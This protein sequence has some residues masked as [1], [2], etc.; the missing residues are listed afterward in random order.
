MMCS[1][2]DDQKQ[3]QVFVV[4]HRRGTAV[5]QLVAQKCVPLLSCEC[6]CTQV[7]T[8]IS[9][10]GTTLRGKDQRHA[11]ETT[12]DRSLP[13]PRKCPKI[14]NDYT[15]AQPHIDKNNRFRQFELAIEERFRTRSFPYRLFTTVIAG[16]SIANAF[17]AYKY[18]VSKNSHEFDSFLDFVHL[19]AYDAMH[20]DY[21]E[22]HSQEQPGSS[23]VACGSMGHSSSKARSRG[24]TD[25]NP[26]RL[27]PTEH[28][29]VPIRSIIGWVGGTQQKCKVCHFPCTTCCLQCSNAESIVPVHAA[30]ANYGHVTK[31]RQCLNVHKR[32]PEEL[33]RTTASASKAVAARR[34]HA[35]RK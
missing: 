6:M 31:V 14:L 23:S 19:V 27:P 22:L 12:T 21:D 10:H 34:R 15:Q 33:G 7:H 5:C 9:T 16:M 35:S 32:K 18:H 25:I 20:N 26:F 30:Q 2:L 24:A 17:V 1:N 13:P 28:T 8:Y 11:D 3:S 4:G 29:A